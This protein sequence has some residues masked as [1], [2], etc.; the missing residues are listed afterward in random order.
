MTNEEYLKLFERDENDCFLNLIIPAEG[1]KKELNLIGKKP[2]DY[3]L[4]EII[5][6]KNYA[7]DMFE[8][9]SE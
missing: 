7:S 3:S 1:D 4:D 5:R 6:M 9:I 2:E 8:K